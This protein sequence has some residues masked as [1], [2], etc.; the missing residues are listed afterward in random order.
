MST[1]RLS[2]RLSK[3]ELALGTI[4]HTSDATIVELIALAGYDW[5]SL[6]LE[7]SSPTIVE[8]ESI[9]RAADLHGVSTLLHIPTADDP[10]LLASLHTGLDGIILQQVT[11]RAD[12]EALVM[13]AM[14][15][16]LGRRGAFSGLRDDQY[17]LESYDDLMVKVNEGLMLGVAIEDPLGVENVDDIISVPG[18]SILFV[19]LH[20]LS[21]AI[22]A[23]NDIRDPRILDAINTCAD[24][25]KRKGIPLG[26]PAYAH[27]V[28]ELRDLGAQ[29]VVSPASE[30]GFI[31]KSFK[32]HLDGVRSSL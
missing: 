1:E 28:A 6:T 5:V 19:G 29:L 25:A 14:F 24:A 32:E 18:I 30:Y 17:G 8:L 12:A 13:A 21:H 23:P 2:T 10:R 16:P 31:L 4:V 11:T 20:D 7:H 15:P 22:G 3:D 9:Q 27:S 26:L